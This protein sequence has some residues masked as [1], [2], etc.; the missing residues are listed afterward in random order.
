MSNPTPINKGGIVQRE[1]DRNDDNSFYMSCKSFN[2][3]NVCQKEDAENISGFINH[4]SSHNK[5][6]SSNMVDN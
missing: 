2:I 4:R 6:F 1:I 3:A 5:F